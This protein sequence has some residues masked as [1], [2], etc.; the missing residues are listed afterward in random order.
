MEQFV[1][2][3]YGFNELARLYFP[4]VAPKSA[5]NRL[6]VWLKTHPHLYEELKLTGYALGQKV[7]SP[8]QVQLI[9]QEFGMPY[10]VPSHESLKSP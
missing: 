4:D 5:S 2:R 7:I 1:I 8:K 6:R 3:A 9:V 10:M